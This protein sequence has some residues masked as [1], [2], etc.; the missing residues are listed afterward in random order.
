M[1]LRLSEIFRRNPYRPTRPKQRLMILGAAVLT[2]LLLFAGL[3]APHIRYIKHKL[4][5]RHPPLPACAPGQ[6]TGCLGGTQGVMLL[7]ATP[8]PA[9]SR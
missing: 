9:A 6:T 7:P 5:M 1:K 3:L 4:D 8:G 2:A